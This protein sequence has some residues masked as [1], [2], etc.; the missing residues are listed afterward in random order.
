MISG[1]FVGLLPRTGCQ[2]SAALTPQ[3]VGVVDLRHHAA[4]RNPA[5]VVIWMD[6]RELLLSRAS[7]RV[8]SAP[9]FSRW[10]QV[11]TLMFSRPRT[12]GPG[13]APLPGSGPAL[14]PGAA[15]PAELSRLHGVARLRLPRAAL[16][17]GLQISHPVQGGLQGLDRVSQLRECHLGISTVLLSSICWGQCWS[18]SSRL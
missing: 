12:P 15:G 3:N 8:K 7:L 1:L 2:A 11:V 9:S 6:R 4:V 5:G 17:A 14:A 10:Q 13:A 18:S 16:P